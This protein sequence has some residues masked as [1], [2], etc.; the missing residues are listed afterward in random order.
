MSPPQYHLEY[1]IIFVPNTRNTKWERMDAGK[2]FFYGA[3]LMLYLLDRIPSM[4]NSSIR[5]IFLVLEFY[6][7]AANDF[8][9]A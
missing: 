1:I 7:V 5:I 4:M 6:L 3:M 8:L 9:V 2:G